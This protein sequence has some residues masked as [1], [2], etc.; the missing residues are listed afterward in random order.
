MDSLEVRPGWGR[1][2]DQG[3]TTLQWRCH[4]QALSLFLYNYY[5]CICVITTGVIPK[6]FLTHTFPKSEGL[7]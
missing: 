1:G 7:C 5:Y 2:L 6:S 3:H 4:R